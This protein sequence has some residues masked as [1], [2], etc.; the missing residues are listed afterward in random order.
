M[1]YVLCI[2]SVRCTLY[3]LYLAFFCPRPGGHGRGGGGAAA[4][5][6]RAAASLSAVR[7]GRRRAPPP[8]M[9]TILYKAMRCP[10][11]HLAALGVSR[12][13]R[14][15]ATTAAAAAGCAVGLAAAA[16]FA[17]PAAAA[18]ITANR[19]L[20]KRHRV[21]LTS[22]P[23]NDDPCGTFGTA[24]DLFAHAKAAG[25]DGLECTVDDFRKSFFP[26]KPYGAIIAAVRELQRSTGIAIVG[27][28]YHVS[29]GG[30]RREHEDGAPGRWDLDFN[31]PGFESAMR[32]KL[33]LDKA[34]GSEYVTF[35]LSLPPEHLNTG[36]LYRDDD[37]YIR[38]SAM[39]IAQLQK[40]CFEQGLNFYVETHIDR[41]SEDVDA[42]CKIMD[43][44]P[45][46]FEVNADIS[47][48]N[49]RA[50]KRGAALEKILAR[51]GHTHQVRCRILR[52]Q[53]EPA[54]G[55]LLDW[56]SSARCLSAWHV[57][58]G[59]SPQT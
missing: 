48:Y 57:S 4:A 34:L 9:A 40:L 29:D 45:K 43:A 21:A 53:S 32:E 33:E 18:P 41:L 35:Q 58:T 27:S 30:W 11:Q 12:R 56:L 44:C 13:P 23:I 39:R 26:G 14:V 25:Y 42:F 19:T 47:H 38:R 24:E 22:W 31:D 37:A 10:L 5:R 8:A 49:Y 50:I 54:V 28:L 17:P 16:G 20:G 59:T 55:W 52:S 6:R 51:V 3:A 1:L 46:Y 15:A 7:S 2:D 36:G